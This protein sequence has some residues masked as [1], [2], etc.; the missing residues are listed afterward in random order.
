[1]KKRRFHIKKDKLRPFLPE[2]ESPFYY[3]MRLTVIFLG[4]LIALLAGLYGLFF[5]DSYG[6]ISKKHIVY[7]SGMSLI[8]TFAMALMIQPGTKTFWITFIII[9]PFAYF[10]MPFI[11]LVL[12]GFLIFHLIITI[13]NNYRNNKQQST[14]GQSDPP[15]R[16]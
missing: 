9:L 12:F 10:L 5:H 16:S 2:Y 7:F 8:G 14:L 4:I 3:K 1:M 13:R 6:F 11:V 15:L